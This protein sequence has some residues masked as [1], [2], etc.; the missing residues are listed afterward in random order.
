MSIDFAT[1]VFNMLT[2]KGIYGREMFETWYAMSVLLQSGLD[3]SGSSR[4][5]SRYADFEQAFA[6]RAV[7]HSGKVIMTWERDEQRMYDRSR[8]S[9][10]KIWRRC[11][12]EGLYK[13][14]AVITTP[15]AADH[16]RR[17][18]HAC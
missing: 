5:A 1:V 18:T 12:T 2:I 8:T 10:P 6:R 3:I 4:T 14:E 16:R 7:G 15:Q 11:K 17:R 13:A 9:S